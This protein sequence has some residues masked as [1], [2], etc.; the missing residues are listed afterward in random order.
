MNQSH[1]HAASML[2]YAHDAAETD[3]PWE[4]WQCKLKTKTIWCDG[5]DE[6]PI[7]HEDF[8]YRRKPKTITVNGIEVPEPAREVPKRGDQYYLADPTSSRKVVRYWTNE[9]EEKSWIEKGV[10]HLTKEAA[11]AHAQAMLV[12]SQRNQSEY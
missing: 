10:L 12:P 3:T 4:R 1:P 7:W 6:H 5:F 11:I 2:L 9:P 8:E